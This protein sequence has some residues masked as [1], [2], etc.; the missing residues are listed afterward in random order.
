M[1]CK[2]SLP[3]IFREQIECSLIDE[4]DRGRERW[5]D[6][7]I[8]RREKRE[9]REREK[10]RAS[11]N[12]QSRQKKKKA[13]IKKKQYHGLLRK[14]TTWKTQKAQGDNVAAKACLFSTLWV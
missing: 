6:G 14:T 11:N 12:K 2:R 10:G 7:E 9:R 1:E 3:G 4:Y 5:R 13:K 8:S